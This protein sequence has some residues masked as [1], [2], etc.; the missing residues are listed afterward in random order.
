MPPTKSVFISIPTVLGQ[1]IAQLQSSGSPITDFSEGSGIRDILEATAVVISGQSQVADQ[2]QLDS[3]LDTATE[4][5]LDAQGGNW[6]VP[7]L[8][9]VQATGQVKITRASS[10]GALVIP[11]GWGQLT[12]PPAAPGA[13]GVAVLTTA[14]AEFADGQASATIAAQ[15]V[16]GGKAGNIA[17]GTKLTPVSPITGVSSDRKSV[18]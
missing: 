13:E 17:M 1:E 7:R 5:A 8:A 6:G 10:V 18:V 9:A 12:V 11:A 14:D 15:A 16:L 2:L 4:E 3:Y